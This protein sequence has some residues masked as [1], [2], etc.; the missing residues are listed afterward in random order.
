MV[1]FYIGE[2]IEEEMGPPDV[3]E[4]HRQHSKLLN[5]LEP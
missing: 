5:A 3:V 2:F 4:Q 1:L